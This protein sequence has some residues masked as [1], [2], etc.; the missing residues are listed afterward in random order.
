MTLRLDAGA[1]EVIA[2][3]HDDAA[4][5]IDE[6]APS[7]PTTVDAGYGAEHVANILAAVT[8]TAGEIAVINLGIAELVRDCADDLGLTEDAIA[9]EFDRMARLA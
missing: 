2:T 1:A 8:E 3:G 6:A 5:K 9:A 4:A 7:A